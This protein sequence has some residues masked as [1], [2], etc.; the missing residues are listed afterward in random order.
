MVALAAPNQTK[1]VAIAQALQYS[2]YFSS[3]G[4]VKFHILDRTQEMF[5][6]FIENITSNVKFS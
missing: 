1:P 5:I 6:K 3:I 2:F 4:N